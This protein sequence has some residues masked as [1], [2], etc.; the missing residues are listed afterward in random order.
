MLSGFA[1]SQT[2]QVI[3]PPMF[4]GP[5]LSHC[6]V[7]GAGANSFCTR[8]RSETSLPTHA[9]RN[10]QA[11][12]AWNQMLRRLWFRDTCPSFPRSWLFLGPG[13]IDPFVV[14]ADF[15]RR[16]FVTVFLV[17]L[18]TAIPSSSGLAAELPG[19]AQQPTKDV[20]CCQE[21]AALERE[22]M[23]TIERLRDNKRADCSRTFQR[24]QP[25]PARFS[26]MIHSGRGLVG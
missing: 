15:C 19:P 9:S 13:E 23:E 25:H 17:R 24:G 10:G 5:T 2:R 22:R 18:A 20:P 26:E 14:P 8:A 12:R 11:A 7:P 1:G 4:V 3:R 6:V 16:V 21:R